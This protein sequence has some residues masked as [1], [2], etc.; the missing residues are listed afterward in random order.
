MFLE[1]LW[2]QI[3]ATIEE[4]FHVG[5]ISSY[6]CAGILWNAGWPDTI[7]RNCYSIGKLSTERCVGGIR[8]F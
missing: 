2:M 7:I 6:E 3:G 8:R 1:L 4:C 5:N